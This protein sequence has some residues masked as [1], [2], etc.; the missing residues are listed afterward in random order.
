M[1]LF[2]GFEIISFMKYK[3]KSMGMG[4]RLVPNKI[5]IKMVQ[6]KINMTMYSHTIF[7]FTIHFQASP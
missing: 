2:I 3:K 6:S 1:I 7:K 5:H 4:S